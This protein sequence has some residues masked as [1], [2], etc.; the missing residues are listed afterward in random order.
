MAS[1]DKKHDESLALVESVANNPT[2]RVKVA[3]ADIDGVLRGKYI[4]AP[5]FPSIVEGGLGFNVFG[6]DI[7]D[8]VYDDDWAS[9][10]MLGF[11]DA[12]VKLDLGTHRAVP[13]DD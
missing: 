5:K 11:P 6:A 9:G 13:W 8:E 2:G 4:H 7:T 10:R 1:S 3:V 12:T